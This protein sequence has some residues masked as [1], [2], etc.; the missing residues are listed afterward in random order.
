[1]RNAV[2]L[3]TSSVEK[4]A[5]QITGVLPESVP[6]VSACTVANAKSPKL[7]KWTA[8]HKR[9]GMR[10]WSREVSSIATSR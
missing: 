7:L 5:N 6:A 2:R 1:M 8:R 9:R 4:T 10:R 3:T